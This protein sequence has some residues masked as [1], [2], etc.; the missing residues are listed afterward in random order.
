MKRVLG[1]DI[2]GANLKWAHTDGAARTLPFELWKQPAKLPAAL[3]ELA[4]GAPIFD[5]V[6]V[7]MTGE[8]CDCF[9]TKRE[10]VHAILDAVAQTF[11]ALPQWIWGNDGQWL[12]LSAA[13]QVPYRV[14]AANWLALATLAGRFVNAGTGLLIDIG[15]TT[16]DVI[17]CLDG[18]PVPQGKTDSERLLADELVYRG[19]RRTPILWS[20]SGR[21]AAELFATT[22]DAFLVLDKIPEDIANLGTADGRPATKHF[23]HA[24]LARMLGDDGET[25][26]ASRTMQLAQSAIAGLTVEI[27]GAI[28]R[29]AGR[30][31][32]L[33]R[34]V[35]VAG[36]GEFFA[37]EIVQNLSWVP[38][39]ALLSWQAKFG[40][41][42]SSAACAFA[43]AFLAAERRDVH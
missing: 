37:R 18:K 16:T 42:L 7:T 13:R 4:A 12:D 35:V 3:S 40:S 17:P 38:P 43:V 28:E 9:E 11:Q 39:P 41:A 19:V 21:L 10:G 24:R 15:S 32:A 5:E 29:V 25:C 26:P 36:S 2:G 1:L 23:A 34:T 14:A 20:T 8:L 6:A 31:P 33:H 30:L 22:L 27:T